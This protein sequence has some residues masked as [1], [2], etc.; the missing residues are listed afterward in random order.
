MAGKKES[1]LLCQISPPCG[2]GKEKILCLP[3]GDNSS[4]I[5]TSQGAN[6]SIVS[7][8]GNVVSDVAGR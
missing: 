6:I 4:F 2:N 7:P 8:E 5:V 1:D 3:L